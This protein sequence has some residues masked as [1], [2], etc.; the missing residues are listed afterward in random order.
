MLSWV[1]QPAIECQPITTPMP[2]TEQRVEAGRCLVHRRPLTYRESQA[3][4]CFWCEPYSGEGA[5]E[6]GLL[7]VTPAELET[8][9][10]E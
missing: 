10:W 6:L 7:F 4:A 2:V 8:W 3:R 9:V 1:R 5:A